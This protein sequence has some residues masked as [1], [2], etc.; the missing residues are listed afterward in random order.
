MS[1]FMF[2][3]LNPKEEKKKEKEN[4]KLQCLGKIHFR[5]SFCC[6]LQLQTLEPYSKI[7]F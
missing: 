3:H 2:L 1:Q 5:S 4:E 7:V 6:L